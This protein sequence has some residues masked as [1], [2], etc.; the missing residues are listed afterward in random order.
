MHPDAADIYCRF[1]SMVECISTRFKMGYI[2][3]F[4]SK[5]TWRTQET[6][7]AIHIVDKPIT[8]YTPDLYFNQ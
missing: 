3:V 8:E 2:I 6:L 5:T 4:I 1:Q 7:Q